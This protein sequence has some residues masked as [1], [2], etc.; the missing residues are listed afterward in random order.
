MLQMTNE[1]KCW[2][3]NCGRELLPSHTG[4][5]PDCHKTGK[6]C[7]ATAIAKIG[8]KVSVETEAVYYRWFRKPISEILGTILLDIVITIV[9]AVVGVCI[10][11]IIGVIAGVLINS[12]AIVMLNIFIHDKVKTTIREI[13][14]N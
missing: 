14:K 6:R 8:L 10:G 9:S 5:C 1:V 11:G 12:S 2:C 3:K 4:E 7:E 13:R